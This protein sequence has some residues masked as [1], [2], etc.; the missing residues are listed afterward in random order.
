MP[1]ADRR[2]L[3]VAR[4]RCQADRPDKAS[5]SPH[6]PA[7][8][9]LAEAGPSY[10]VARST[11]SSSRGGAQTSAMAGAHSK[12]P[13]NTGGSVT[14]GAEDTPVKGQL[15]TYNTAPTRDGRLKA[16]NLRLL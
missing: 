9:A 14:R 6:K 11:E 16:V 7:A 15:V 8:R 2:A 1:R 4:G 10:W 5:A 13:A 12:P 3:G